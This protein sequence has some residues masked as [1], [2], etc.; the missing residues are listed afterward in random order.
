MAEAL[1]TRQVDAL[2]VV[3]P[4][5]GGL[6]N[7]AVAAVTRAGGAPKFIPIAEAKGIAQRSNAME[8][9]EGVRGA[10]GGEPPRPEGLGRGRGHAAHVF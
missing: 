4:T 5:T 3:A 10:F 6:A 9:T 1:K 2:F 8:S 7:E